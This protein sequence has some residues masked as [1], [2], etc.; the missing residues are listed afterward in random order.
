MSTFLFL[1]AVNIELANLSL[2]NTALLPSFFITVK[3]LNCTLSK[4]VNLDPHAGQSLLL[5]IAEPSSVGLESFTCVSVLLQKG[6]KDMYKLESY[7]DYLVTV[8]HKN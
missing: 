2:L 5:L 3:S 4:E 1:N 7:E 8:F 6:Y